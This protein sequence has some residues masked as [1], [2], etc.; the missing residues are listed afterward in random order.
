MRKETILIINYWIAYSYERKIVNEELN[1]A[2]KKQINGGIPS[3][4]C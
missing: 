1:N 3:F 2:L 4:L